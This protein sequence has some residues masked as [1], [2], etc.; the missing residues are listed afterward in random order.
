MLEQILTGP[1]AWRADTIDAPVRL[2][3]STASPILAALDTTIREL[4]E[5]L[6]P[7]TDVALADTRALTARGLRP[8]RRSGVGARVRD[9]P[10]VAAG[11]YSPDAM[12]LAYWLIGQ[13][14]AAVTQNVQGTGSTTSRT[15]A[16]TSAT[17]PA[18]R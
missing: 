1:Q 14:L 5:N 15:P 13:M 6:L 12:R 3:S 8:A 10:R 2:V 9:S 16:G 11:Q 18:S 4:R 7:V 17:A